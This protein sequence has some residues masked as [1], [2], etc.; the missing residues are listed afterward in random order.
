MLS[1]VVHEAS[2]SAG[3]C[4]SDRD[5]CRGTENYATLNRFSRMK[6]SRSISSRRWR[7]NASV[8]SS[9]TLTRHFRALTRCSTFPIPR[10]DGPDIRVDGNRL[11]YR[12]NFV[13]G[14]SYTRTPLPLSMERRGEDTDSLG[15]RWPESLPAPGR[16]SP[17]DPGG[18]GGRRRQGR[19]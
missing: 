8:R 9:P 3:Q 15:M 10:T 6:L 18:G 1:E 7:M 17:A 16:G 2:L 19:L 5:P 14:N 12:R 4:F 11:K 13:L